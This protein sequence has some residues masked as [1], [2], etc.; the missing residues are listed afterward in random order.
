MPFTRLLRH[1]L[2]VT[3]WAAG[4][5]LIVSIVIICTS[6]PLVTRLPQARAK[7]IRP[8]TLSP[9][10]RFGHA[11]A[12]DR[13]R[14]E[15]IG[16]RS[17][18]LCTDRQDPACTS[19]EGLRWGS[20]A[21]LIDLRRQS[22]CPITVSGGTERGHADGVYTH[23]NGYK[24]DVM[25]NRCVDGFIESRYRYAGERG[26]GALMY[27]APNG[28]TYCDEHGSHWDIVFSADWHPSNHELGG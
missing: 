4:W 13:L 16:W 21:G 8:V 17:S 11:A 19:F 2:H 23:Y 22:G 20:I 14:A 18:G 1:M 12:L 25:P 5:L 15:G 3:A 24:M 9:D 27:K 28:F 7:A 10:V 6:T 26:D